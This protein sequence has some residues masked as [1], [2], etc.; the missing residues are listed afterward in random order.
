[1]VWSIEYSWRP[2]SS[3]AAMESCRNGQSFCGIRNIDGFFG[4]E[5][6]KIFELRRKSCFLYRTGRF[7]DFLV[8]KDD[9]N[10]AKHHY[11]MQCVAT[12]TALFSMCFDSYVSGFPAIS[13]KLFND[14]KPFLY[15]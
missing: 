13:V 12:Y 8:R 15:R 6:Y 2:A 7:V 4:N 14:I 5:E 3:S 1:M 10:K 9:A 11:I